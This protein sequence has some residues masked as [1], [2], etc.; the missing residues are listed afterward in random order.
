METVLAAVLLKN[1]MRT[2]L[3]I[4]LLD[5]LQSSCPRVPTILYQ[6]SDVSSH[7]VQITMIMG[8]LPPLRSFQNAR[9]ADPCLWTGYDRNDEI[10]DKWLKNECQKR[11]MFVL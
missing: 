7:F 6:H 3:W 10:E 11:R 1:S 5:F 2:E 8:C 9:V 4:C